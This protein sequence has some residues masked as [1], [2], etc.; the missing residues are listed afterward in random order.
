MEVEVEVFM[1]SR[2]SRLQF[3]STE[4]KVEGFS[5][6]DKVHKIAWSLGLVLE[7]EK[8]PI[9][10]GREFDLK[11]IKTCYRSRNKRYIYV[12]LSQVNLTDVR[13]VS[14]DLGYLTLD[15]PSSRHLFN[16]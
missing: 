8:G 13:L 2:A 12:P 11:S 3:W 4:V 10:I 14:P 15:F 6:M 9:C 16:M 5:G 7:M 1:Y